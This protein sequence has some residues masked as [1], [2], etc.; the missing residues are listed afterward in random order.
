MRLEVTMSEPQSVEETAYPPVLAAAIVLNFAQTLTTSINTF[1]SG[2]DQGRHQRAVTG[3]PVSL[4][5]AGVSTGVCRA[6]S[7][8][9][10]SSMLPHG[11]SAL[12]LAGNSRH[13]APANAQLLRSTPLS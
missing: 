4:T 2:P 10:T 6:P 11:S 1:G 5:C 9:Y 7:S 13:S 12:A 8:G 3:K